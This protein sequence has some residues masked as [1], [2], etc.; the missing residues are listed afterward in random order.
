MLACR[1]SQV[2]PCQRVGKAASTDSRTA[3]LACVAM[4]MML[5]I[6]SFG[7][8][9]PEHRDDARA[10]DPSALSSAGDFIRQEIED[11]LVLPNNVR[12]QRL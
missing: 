10:S 11:V 1:P 6:R 9:L 3:M 4:H 7:S 12:L 2:D 5:L 8:G